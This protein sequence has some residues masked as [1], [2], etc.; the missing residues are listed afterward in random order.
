MANE[1]NIIRSVIDDAVQLPHVASPAALDTNNQEAIRA[2]R[3]LE[4]LQ[5]RIQFRIAQIN[6]DP[7]LSTEDKMGLVARLEGAL[8]SGDSN[9]IIYAL[10]SVS[11]AAQAAREEE[12]SNQ[13]LDES[14]NQIIRAITTT[15][16][17]VAT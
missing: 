15:A 1:G 4:E 11:T 10:N 12:S 8:Q 7:N 9:R 16:A 6:A 2:A 14:Y 17:L 3:E 5:A 13:V